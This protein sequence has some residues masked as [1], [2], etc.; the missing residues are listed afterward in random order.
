MDC[1]DCGLDC[2]L[3]VPWF[4]WMVVIGLVAEAALEAPVSTV[5][6]EKEETPEESAEETPEE[7]PEL[8]TGL[9]GVIVE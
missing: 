4:A 7:T 5:L 3:C 2:A 1:M 6:E 9:M 8:S